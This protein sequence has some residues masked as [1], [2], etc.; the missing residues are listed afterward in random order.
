MMN[1]LAELPFVDI[2]DSK[3]NKAFF[4]RVDNPLDYK[5][6]VNSAKTFVE[7]IE[8][9]PF[10]NNSNVLYRIAC[11]MTESG[12]IKSESARGFF[13]TLDKLLLPR[14]SKSQNDS[15]ILKRRQM[16][17]IPDIASE[18]GI[19]SIKLLNFLAVIGWIDC[20]TVQPTI[21]SIN[22]GVLRKN[23]RMP[24]GYTI[25]RKGERLIESKYKAMCK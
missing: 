12:L 8:K 24:F 10:M 4:W 11:D 3:A 6:G 22:E 5:C 9:Y 21:E 1:Y 25:T 16:R 7:F 23:S 20:I 19:T 13:N 14:N 17:S 15:S 18:I 2:F